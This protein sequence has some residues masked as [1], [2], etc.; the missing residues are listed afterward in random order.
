MLQEEKGLSKELSAC[1]TR[2]E[3]V[4]KSRGANAPSSKVMG[5]KLSMDQSRVAA[6]QE[7][8]GLSET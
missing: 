1:S 2:K 5:E 4:G 8:T 7:A 6:T 3:T